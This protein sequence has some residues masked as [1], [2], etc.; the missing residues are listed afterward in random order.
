MIL[1]RQDWTNLMYWTNL[2]GLDI[3]E[4]IKQNSKAQLWIGLK[5]RQY[6]QNCHKKVLATSCW[7]VLYMKITLG[8]IHKLH[9]PK[10]PIFDPIPPIVTSYFITPMRWRHPK[11]FSHSDKSHLINT[12]GSLEGVIGANC[13][14]VFIL[15]LLAHQPLY[16]YNCAP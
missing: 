11:F 13:T 12:R 3:L 4:W 1:I 16:S 8:T 14:V 2:T 9:H 15:L 10:I 6:Y 5:L 7:K